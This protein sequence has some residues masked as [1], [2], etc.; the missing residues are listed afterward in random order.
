[1][2]YKWYSL[3]VIY[4]TLDKYE[5]FTGYKVIPSDQRRVIEQT[6][7]IYSPLGRALEIQ[8]KAI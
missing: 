7:V 6:K 4:A 5:Y 2:K 1:M 8:K 3:F